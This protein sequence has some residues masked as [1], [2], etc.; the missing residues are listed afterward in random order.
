M[1]AAVR[2]PSCRKYMLVEPADR[3]RVVACLACK[4]PVRVPELEPVDF[5]ADPA[6]LPAARPLPPA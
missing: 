3:G 4:S 5:D 6:G 1:V 2:C